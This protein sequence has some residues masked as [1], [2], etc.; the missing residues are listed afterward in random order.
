MTI[1][2]FIFFASC[3]LAAQAQAAQPDCGGAFQPCC[4]GIESCRTGLSCI[5]RGAAG[6]ICEPC[7]DPFSQPCPSGQY[8]SS[9]Q[10]V[11]TAST[12]TRTQ[13]GFSFHSL[14]SKRCI[15]VCFSQETGI[16]Q[17]NVLHVAQSGNRAAM[18]WTAC[19]RE[20]SSAILN[21]IAVWLQSTSGIRRSSFQVRNMHTCPTMSACQAGSGTGSAYQVE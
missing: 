13:E 15:D 3:L 6:V 7:G 14:D 5:D 12:G 10:L 20:S 11:P 16:R 2:K 4:A 21:R 8:C 19:A 1:L 18:S 9:S 17:Y